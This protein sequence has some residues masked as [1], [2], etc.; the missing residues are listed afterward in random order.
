MRAFT[1]FFALP[2]VYAASL[3]VKDE[4]GISTS[5]ET[6]CPQGKWAEEC[7]V[8]QSALSTLADRSVEVQ[9]RAGESGSWCYKPASEAFWGAASAACC[10]E[11]NGSMRDDRRCYGLKNSGNRCTKFYECCKNK[12]RSGNRPGKDKCH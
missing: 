12:F 4:Q 3:G 6:L 7:Q 9:A 2:I 8:Q 5:T 11:V 10:N 1:L